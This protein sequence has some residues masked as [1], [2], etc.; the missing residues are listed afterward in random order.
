[1]AV[2]KLS[3]ST[4]RNWPGQDI[5]GVEKRGMSSTEKEELIRRRETSTYSGTRANNMRSV[6]EEGTYC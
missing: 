5:R 2:P 3:C 6:D 4:A 1:M